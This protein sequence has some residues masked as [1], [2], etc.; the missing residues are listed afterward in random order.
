M[1]TSAALPSPHL[2]PDP[3]ALIGPNA[4]M[5][6]AAAMEE[7]LGQRETRAIFADAQVSPMPRGDLMIAEDFALR[8][9]RWLALHEP[10]ESY[11]IAHEA[12]LRTA[13]YIIANRIPPLAVRLLR[14]LPAP[15]AAPLLMQAIRR[16][17]W[18]FAGAG[19]FEPDG[20][21]HFTMDRSA[22]SDIGLPPASLFHWYAAVFTRLF[23]RLVAPGCRCRDLDSDEPIAARHRF[24]IVRTQ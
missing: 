2:H 9:H 14:S 21:W 19:H 15:I 16:H 3:V 5:Q 10:I 11:A 12:G 23:D 20:A 7:R 22:A 24:E 4:V 13:D 18:T 6:L 1:S 17:A 8:L